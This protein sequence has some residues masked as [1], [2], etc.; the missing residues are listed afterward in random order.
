MPSPQISLM[1]PV[2]PFVATITRLPVVIALRL[3]S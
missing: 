3:R 2:A 1:T